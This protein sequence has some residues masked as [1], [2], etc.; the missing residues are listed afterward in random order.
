MNGNRIRAG[1]KVRAFFIQNKDFRRRLGWAD[2]AIIQSGAFFKDHFLMPPNTA[3]GTATLESANKQ[4]PSTWRVA[5][6]LSWAP[7]IDVYGGINIW[8]HCK[9]VV[10]LSGDI[11][12]PKSWV[13]YKVGF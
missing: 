4:F 13:F 5:L 6:G 1:E 3:L 9:S 2:E 7:E 12:K 8:Y 11:C 10:A